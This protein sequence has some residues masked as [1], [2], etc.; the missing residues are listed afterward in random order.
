VLTSK[1]LRV[2]R[3]VAR[4]VRS[5]HPSAVG[6]SARRRRRLA[7]GAHSS[8][9]IALSE[10]VAWLYRSQDAG[11]EDGSR[12]FRI[13]GGWSACYPEVTGYNLYTLF[14]DAHQSGRSESFERAVRMADWLLTVQFPSGAY[15]GSYVDKPAIPVVFNTAQ[16]LQGLIRAGQETARGS[17]LEAARRAADWLV[18]VQDADGAWRQYCYI[19]AFRVT[20]TRIAYPLL[21]AWK[22]TKDEKYRAGAIRSL[23]HV[24]STQQPNGWFPDCDNSLELVDQPN[25]HTIAYTVEGLLE[26]GYILG[27]ETFVAAGRRCADALLRSFEAASVLRGRY[28]AQWN[29]TVPSVCLT[30]CAQTARNWLSLYS[31]TRDKTYLDAAVSMNDYLCASQ[32]VETSDAALRGALSGSEPLGGEYQPYAFPS[33]ATKYFCDA[34]IA[35]RR[36][37]AKSSPSES[38]ARRY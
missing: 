22:E 6:Y 25:T 16:I 4:V 34:L 19:G 7:T 29:A 8:R 35:E 1:G 27:D 37:L 5:L 17:Y 14:D 26:S 28:D 20:D 10:A 9:V 15:P 13:F 2:L 11:R 31:W 32:D 18:S 3:P 21:E 30:G 12:C 24:I 23:R 36:L 38:A 33:W